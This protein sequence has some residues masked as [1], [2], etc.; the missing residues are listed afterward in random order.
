MYERERAAAHERIRLGAPFLFGIG[1]LGSLLGFWTTSMFLPAPFPAAVAVGIALLLIFAIARL[2][3]EVMDWKHGAEAERRVGDSLE[4]LVPLG[5]ITLYDRSIRGRGGNIDAVTVGPPGVFVIETKWR[6][7]RVEVIN[8]RLEVGGRDQ[9]DIVRQVVELSLF[10]QISIATSMNKH[11]LTV[12]PIICI[13]NRSV[14]KGIRTSGVPVVD[15]KSIGTH[16]RQLPQVLT[17]A[18]VQKIAT[19]LDNALPPFDRR[20]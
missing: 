16:M 15:A 4:K 5:F 19:D 18:E 10:V 17:Q 11:R 3:P 20:R 14:D 7:R 6:K 8:R 12:M 2:T 1:G 13:G 9:P